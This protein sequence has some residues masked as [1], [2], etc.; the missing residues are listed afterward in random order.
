MIL[1]CIVL[2]C[3]QCI[4]EF[5]CY[6]LLSFPFPTSFHFS[7]PLSPA[8]HLFS[9]LSPLLSSRYLSSSL[10]S[11]PTSL[12][13]PLFPA[14]LPPP[15]FPASL[16]HLF[17]LTHTNL[18]TPPLLIF[19]LFSSIIPL[20][21]PSVPSLVQ[22]SFFPVSG[23]FPWVFHLLHS[24]CEGNDYGSLKCMILEPVMLKSIVVKALS[25]LHGSV[26]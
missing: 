20:T 12:S 8:P 17:A 22:S 15:L 14:S 7:P 3:I 10:T 4:V 24:E 13:P 21:H 26:C 6:Y 19:L 2:Y 23:N 11:L 16:P 18:S 9:P 5:P 1:Y 25:Q